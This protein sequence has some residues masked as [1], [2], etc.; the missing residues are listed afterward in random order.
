MAPRATGTP[1]SPHSLFPC[2]SSRWA[3]TPAVA[4]V[5]MMNNRNGTDNPDPLQFNNVDAR[6]YGFDMDWAGQLDDQWSLSGIVNYVRGERDDT[7]DNLY[8]IAPAN[9]SFRLNYAGANWT[10]GVEGVV[11]DRQDKVSD[12]NGERETSGYGLVNLSATWQATGQLQLAAGVD[13]LLDREYEDH[14]NGYNRAVNPDIA[15]G[16]RLP[17]YGINAFAR[18]MYQF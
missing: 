1:S 11:Y 8:R 14:L 12:T 13:N 6:L 18:V 15:S 3:K 17:G 7:S 2:L 16:E 9:A 4:L 10:A 5:R